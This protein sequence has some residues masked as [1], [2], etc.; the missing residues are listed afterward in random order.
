MNKLVK[1]LLATI[2]ACSV[3]I[4]ILTPLAIVLFWGYYFNLSTIASNILITIGG[5]GSLFRAIK[6][7]WLNEND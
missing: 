1:V 6:I 3:V 5:L 2:G 4:E 7:G